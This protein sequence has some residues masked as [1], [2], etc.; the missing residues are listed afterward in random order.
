MKLTLRGKV[1]LFVLACVVVNIIVHFV[2]PW[3]MI[4]VRSK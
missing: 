1:V 3:D 4:W 2:F